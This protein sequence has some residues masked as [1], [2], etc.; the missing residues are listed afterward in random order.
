MGPAKERG[1]RKPETEAD[2]NFP[3]CSPVCSL[4]RQQQHQEL[5][6]NADPQAPPCSYRI[7]SYGAVPRNLCFTTPPDDSAARENLSSTTVECSNE[8]LPF[9]EHLLC[10]R[11]WV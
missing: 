5:A 9:V 8:G 3:H 6:G 2:L 11:H 4:S 1:E 7:K 10:A